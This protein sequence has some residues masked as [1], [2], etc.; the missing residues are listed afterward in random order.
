M[1]AFSWFSLKNHWFYCIYKI[2]K[3]FHWKHAGFALK[4]LIFINPYVFASTI[5][6]NEPPGLVGLFFWIVCLLF[7]LG[8]CL[9][10]D[11]MVFDNC[12]NHKLGC[13]RLIGSELNSMHQFTWDHMIGLFSWE[14]SV[15]L[16]CVGQFS[17]EPPPCVVTNTFTCFPFTHVSMF[18]Q[19]ANH[20]ICWG[21][22]MQVMDHDI[23]RSSLHTCKL[24]LAQHLCKTLIFIVFSW[25][26][27]AKSLRNQWN[28]EKCQATM[29][30]DMHTTCA[31]VAR[32]WGGPSISLFSLKKY[33]KTLGLS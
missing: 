23:T 7:V 18:W 4:A 19:H 29:T 3:W 6:M 26:Y 2:F 31:E 21:Q 16:P 15:E 32:L 25:K 20:V 1:L 10:S 27:I 33:S 12:F 30:Q 5:F 8:G 22:L 11:P 24:V 13:A 17:G 14:L 9:V 28:F